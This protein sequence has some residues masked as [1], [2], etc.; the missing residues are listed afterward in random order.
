MEDSPILEQMRKDKEAKK[1]RKDK[2]GKPDYTAP[3]VVLA[4]II[5]LAILAFQ[6]IKVV[7]KGDPL[8]FFFL[9]EKVVESEPVKTLQEA[10]KDKSAGPVY[11][12]YLTEKDKEEESL[13]TIETR[14]QDGVSIRFIFKV[15]EPI[16]KTTKYHVR[17]MIRREANKYTTQQIIN[18]EFDVDKL[19]SEVGIKWKFQ[20]YQLPEVVKQRIERLRQAKYEVEKAKLEAEAMKRVFEAQVKEA[21]KHRQME[22][23]KHKM[24]LQEMQRE[25]ERLLFEAETQRMLR[26]QNN[27]KGD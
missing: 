12:V 14:L 6:S 10:L 13:F 4:L 27:L 19:I 26:E 1:L 21:E 15:Q 8:N 5:A 24:R 22:E 17:N 3:V 7:S 18:Q 23:I 9:K 2:R 11:K 25:R 20:D 16:D